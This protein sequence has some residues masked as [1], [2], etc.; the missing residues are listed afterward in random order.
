M[1]AEQGRAGR[2]GAGRGGA[3]PFLRQVTQY[4]VAVIQDRQVWRPAAA[5]TTA[6]RKTFL[7][8]LFLFSKKK[9]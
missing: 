5:A 6:T 1:V 7:R 3:D 2:G 8:I 4:L 9:V